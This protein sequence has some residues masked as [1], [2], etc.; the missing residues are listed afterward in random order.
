MVR[1]D[2]VGAIF[3]AEKASS[4]VRTRY[5]DTRYHFIMD[6]L[7]DGFIK[8]IFVTILETFGDVLRE[9]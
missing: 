9:D 2:N 6:H 5:M 3:I 4:G 7:E 8:I 1:T